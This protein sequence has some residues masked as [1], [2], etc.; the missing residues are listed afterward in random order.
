MKLIGIFNILRLCLSYK[1]KE[2]QN[3]EEKN[4][5]HIKTIPVESGKIQQCLKPIVNA[6]K[7]TSVNIFMLSDMTLNVTKMRSTNNTWKY[8][9]R[10][11]TW[12]QDY[13]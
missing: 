1:F 12:L 11:I 4:S 8:L 9:F 3:N 7:S 6:S 2:S 10:V 13:N 5:L